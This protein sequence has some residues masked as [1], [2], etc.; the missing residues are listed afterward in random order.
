MR[1]VLKLGPGLNLGQQSWGHTRRITPGAK[2]G[3]GV[4][5]G[6][7]LRLKLGLNLWLKMGLGPKIGLLLGLMLE[8]CMGLRLKF[9]EIKIWAENRGRG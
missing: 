8:M 6:L 3:A 9:F 7:N 5:P 1:L 4:K 2:D